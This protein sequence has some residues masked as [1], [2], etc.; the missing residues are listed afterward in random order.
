MS[1]ATSVKDEIRRL[2]D[3]LPDDC[4]WDDAMYRIYVRQVIEAGLADV[5]A[6]RT[7]SHEDIHH[8][9]GLDS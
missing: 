9:F 2:I 1:Q 8:E 5:T 6:G 4:T 3:E 7:V